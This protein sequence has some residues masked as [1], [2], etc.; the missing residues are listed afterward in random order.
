MF[1]RLSAQTP[2][3]SQRRQYDRKYGKKIKISGKAVMQCNVIYKCS[4][5]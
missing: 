1:C 5:Y 3:L 4:S 2:I